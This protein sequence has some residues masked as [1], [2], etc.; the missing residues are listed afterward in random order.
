MSCTGTP[1]VMQ[2]MRGIPASTDST[3]ASVA[4]GGGTKISAT[5]APVPE[6]ACSTESNTGTASSNIWPPRPGVTPATTWVP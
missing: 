3:T 1:S 5:L 2:A 6:T 4:K